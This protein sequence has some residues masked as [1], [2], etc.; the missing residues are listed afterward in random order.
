[1]EI[2]PA[3]DR[4]R[5]LT[6]LRQEL[7]R[8]QEVV[9]RL[10]ADD[11]S[12]STRRGMF[13][14]VA[15]AAGG[16]V[17]AAALAGGK[18]ALAN[19]PN[20]ITIGSIKS[21]TAGSTGVYTEYAGPATSS[22]FVYA[23]GNPGLDFGVAFPAAIA[24]M[25]RLN[26]PTGVLGDSN[27][28][29]GNGVVGRATG[30]DATGVLGEGT[31]NGV[32]GRTTAPGSGVRAEATSLGGTGVLAHGYAYGVYTDATPGYGLSSIGETA[33]IQLHPAAQLPPLTRTNN[34]FAGEID[35]DANRDVWY[36]VADGAPGMWRK[37]AG[38]ATA[39]AFHPIEPARVYDSRLAASTPSGPMAPNTNRVISV[40]DGRDA[41]GAVVTPDV[42]PA[43][44]TAVT[45]NLTVAGPTGPN[46][47]SAVPGDATGFT[48][49]TINFPGGFDAANGSVVKLDADRQV[50]LFCGDQSGSTHV[51]LDITGYYV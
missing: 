39:G 28:A 9:A 11:R 49:S 44:A 42:V 17:A 30:T 16:A 38:P 46:F 23:A 19:D 45:F 26:H 2:N 6:A 1:M 13:K 31:D 33:A 20:D 50:K 27:V 8:M 43:G 34:H 41:T 35:V 48:T 47:V 4:E 29:S 7:A 3:H 25:A 15:G 22:T 5:E 21:T 10:A 37:L 14:V 12:P 24:G 32:Y 40:K 36:C 51:I 18:P